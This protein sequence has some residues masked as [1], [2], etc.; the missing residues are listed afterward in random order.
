MNANF[1][2]YIANLALKMN[3]CVMNVQLGTISNKIFRVKS[4]RYVKSDVIY[5][6]ILQENALNVKN[7]FL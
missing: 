5:V 7:D 1:A 2:I 4:V 6:R 3:I